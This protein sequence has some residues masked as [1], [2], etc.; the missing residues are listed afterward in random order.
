MTKNTSTLQPFQPFKPFKPFYMETTA[1]IMIRK[2]TNSRV[3]EVDF[4]HLEFGKY[5]SDH[6][7]V[8]DYAHGVWK[9]PQIVPYANLSM[10]P[11]ALALHYGQTVFEGMKAF[12]MHDG[13]INIFRMD[14]H[15]DR[16]VRSLQRMCMAVVPKDIFVEGLRRLVELDKDWVPSKPGHALYLP[17]AR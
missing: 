12:R 16:F 5:I 8:C 11:S 7:L 15:Y 6:M 9:D 1:D 2:T 3:K 10:S 14:K 17:V 4:N 13:S